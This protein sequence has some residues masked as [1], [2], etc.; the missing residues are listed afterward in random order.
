MVENNVLHV[1]DSQ[2]KYLLVATV[3]GVFIYIYIY[4][5][6][7]SL[8]EATT[9]GSAAATSLQPPCY[10]LKQRRCAEVSLTGTSQ[11]SG[12]ILG[13]RQE[14]G[15]SCGFFTPPLAH[16][17]SL[18]PEAGCS[19]FISVPT[20]TGGIAGPPH[21]DLSL[22]VFVSGFWLC[23]EWGQVWRGGG[24]VRC[25]FFGGEGRKASNSSDGE[26]PT[27]SLASRLAPPCLPSRCRWWMFMCTLSPNRPQSDLRCRRR[28]AGS[29]PTKVLPSL[30]LSSHLSLF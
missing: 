21:A 1:Y 12:R 5:L 27:F 29:S 22:A 18:K 10:A 9:L 20:H 17:T 14:R 24:G 2:C 25:S 30:A 4:L 11:A 16:C 15:A 6:F 3:S 7:L 8:F 13:P 23:C 19:G 26:D 28:R